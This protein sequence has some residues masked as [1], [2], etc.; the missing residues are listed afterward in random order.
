M[1]DAPKVC[2]GCGEDL[3][4]TVRYEENLYREIICLLTCLGLLG[5]IFQLSWSKITAFVVG[6]VSDKQDLDLTSPQPKKS[7]RIVDR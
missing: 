5:A 1:D 2:T 3:D 4:K 7:I 6:S